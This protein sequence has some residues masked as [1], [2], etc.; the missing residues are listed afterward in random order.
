MIDYTFTSVSHRGKV[1]VVEQPQLNGGRVVDALPQLSP[2]HIPLSS[3]G[4]C[5]QARRLHHFHVQVLLLL[6]LL[7]PAPIAA[8]FVPQTITLQ[9]VQLRG[10]RRRNGGQRPLLVVAW[11]QWR[12]Q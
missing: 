12:L 10:L 6:L 9:H 1:R 8:P 3:S 7:F 11:L 2:A 5:F 4:S